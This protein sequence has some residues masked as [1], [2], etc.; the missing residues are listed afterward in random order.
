MP[1]S[2]WKLDTKGVPA[3][4]RPLKIVRLMEARFIRGIPSRRMLMIIVRWLN[5]SWNGERILA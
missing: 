1:S 2:K 5:K 3:T 4:H